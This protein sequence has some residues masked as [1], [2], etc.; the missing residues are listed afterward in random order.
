MKHILSACIA[1]FCANLNAASI[2]SIEQVGSSSGSY[3]L[4]F[5]NAGILPKSFNT[6]EP[7]SAIIL[8]FPNTNSGLTSRELGVE[9][10]GIYNVNIH[11]AD[12]RTRA[13]INLAFPMEY[14]VN[15][16]NNDVV[17]T[18]NTSSVRKA[19]EVN[20]NNN[21]TK[22]SQVAGLMPSFRIGENEDGGVKGIFTFNLPSEKTAVNVRTEGNF[23]VADIAGYKVSK[24]DQKRL[25]VSDYATPVDYIDIKNGTKG[26]RISLKMKKDYEFI[27]YQT[28]TTYA[29]EAYKSIDRNSAKEQLKNISGFN[30]HRDYKGKPLSLNFQDIEI[31]AVLQIIAEFTGQN[32]VVSD[33]VSGNITLRLDNVPSDL[34]LDIILKSKSLGKRTNNNVTYIGPES[35][36]NRSEIEALQAIQDKSSKTPPKT[37]LIQVKYADATELQTIIEK[38]RETGTNQDGRGGGDAILSERGRITVDKRTNTLIVSDIPEKLAMVRDLIA[39]LDEPVRQVLVDARLVKT[40]DSFERELGVRFS[41]VARTGNQLGQGGLNT[42]SFGETSSGY[43]NNIDYSPYH[44]PSL[45]PSKNGS[46]TVN[47]YPDVYKRLGVNIGGVESAAQLGL[48]ILSGDFLIGLELAAME[49]EGKVEIL[50]SPRIVTQDGSSAKISTGKQIPVTT[51]VDGTPTQAQK[52][53]TLSLEVTPRITPNNMVN[54]ELQI[55]DD[56]ID[57]Q[58]QGF[59][60][61]TDFTLSTNALNTN[62]LVDNGETLVLGG[63]YK[64][65]QAGNV[66]KVPLLGDIPLVGNAFKTNTKR[67]DKDEMLVFITPRIIDKRMVQ[68]DKFSNLR[69]N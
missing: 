47:T 21:S 69:D 37:D 42:S 54:M 20:N 32:I 31:R 16:S 9:K 45:V 66:K 30:E 27:A 48:A 2:T 51:V 41:N 23:I 8:D 49:T 19:R 4:I 52:D 35:S 5:K 34:A 63:F 67:F 68:N 39:K 10:S 25:D 59:G 7:N 15:L 57:Q 6:N 24:A 65:S 36:L 29:I 12:N 60:G 17:V 56:N 26:S 13:V 46:T 55:T 44:A 33:E 64:Q 1:L 3:Q 38:S 40:T 43:Q 50:S 61:G 14:K 53:V 22:V 62:V 58:V 18:L 28:G 11:E